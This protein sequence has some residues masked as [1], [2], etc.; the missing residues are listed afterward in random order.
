MSLATRIA[1]DDGIVRRP[2][3]LLVKAATKSQIA[4]RRRTF[5]ASTESLDSH[6]EIVEQVWDLERFNRNPVI[7]FG[8]DSRALPVGK[9]VSAKVVK[10]DDGAPQ[11]EIE[12]Q[13]ASAEANP[14]AENVWQ[15]LCEETLR[16]CSVGFR[17]GDIRCEMRDGVEVYVLSNNDLFELSIVPM[18]SNPETI[19]KMHARAVRTT[20]TT[21]TA[22]ET[23]MDIKEMET[24][25]VAAEKLAAERDVS[26]KALT[27]A[28]AALVIERDTAV[29][30]RETAATELATAQR[31]LAEATVSLT[32]KTQTEK[33][34]QDALLAKT[35]DDLVGVKILP[36][37][38][39]AQLELAKSN[40][41]LFEKLMSQ[42]PVL[43]LL[44]ASP[45][46]AEP[47]TLDQSAAAAPTGDSLLAEASKEAAALNAQG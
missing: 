43:A 33:E 19:A 32:A 42:R 37:E 3:G 38:R 27:E 44:G 22:T 9:G 7:L 2:D 34:A 41:A 17:P 23:D 46:K 29:T 35:I 39:D 20:A 12:V 26:L 40:P 10:G 21:P 30:A 6:G 28:N 11:L 4:G 25:A 18:G 15:S 31:E 47:T 16:A 1:P 24:R 13:F 36:T 5:I 14:L 45:I 8:H